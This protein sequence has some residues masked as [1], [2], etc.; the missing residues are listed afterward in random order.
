[1]ARGGHGLPKV[2]LGSAMPDPSTPCGWAI[3]E[4]AVLYPLGHPAPF[5]HESVLIYHLLGFAQSVYLC[6]PGCLQFGEFLLVGGGSD[7]DVFIARV[8]AWS[9]VCS[10]QEGQRKNSGTCK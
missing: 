5:A 3:P 4:T 7:G 9:W 1:M 8:R 10:L 6:F 2:S